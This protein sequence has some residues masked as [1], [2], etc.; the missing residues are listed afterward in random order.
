M[1]VVVLLL[2]LFLLAVLLRAIVLLFAL[3]SVQ[4]EAQVLESNPLLEAFGNARTLRN[5]N[6]SRFG[7]FIELQFVLLDARGAPRGRSG[8]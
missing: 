8:L 4:V 7:K 6:S 5:D 3:L 2:L 1:V